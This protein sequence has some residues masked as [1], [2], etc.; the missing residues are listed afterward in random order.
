MIRIGRRAECPDVPVPPTPIRV[1]TWNVRHGLDLRTGR[2]DLAAVAAVIDALQVDVVALQEVDREQP[3]SGGAD[4]VA[5]LA[6]ALGWHG[7][8]APTLFG[9]PGGRWRPGPGTAVDP[10]GQAYGIGLLSRHPLRAVTRRALP[11]TARGDRWR[12][13]APWDNEPRVLL[14]AE[15][16]ATGVVVSST[17]LS[18]LPWRGLRQLRVA[19]GVAAAAAGAAV[20]M[21][22]LNLPRRLLRPALS[23]APWHTVHAGP[24]FPTWRPGLALD[25]ILTRCCRLREVRVGTGGPSDHLPVVGLLEPG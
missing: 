21:G 9:T 10:G 12:R 6:T 22:D 5:A 17:H 19:M 25:H 1:A 4:Q 13:S 18:Y 16:G 7:V 11:G 14:R 2:V 20:L 3:R 15:V 24:T 23:R 8:F